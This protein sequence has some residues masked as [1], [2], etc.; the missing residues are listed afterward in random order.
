MYLFSEKKKKKK[1]KKWWLSQSIY[2]I[3]Y[4]KTLSQLQ[5]QNVQFQFKFQFVLTFKFSNLYPLV[6]GYGMIAIHI[7]WV[8]MFVCVRI[9]SQKQTLFQNSLDYLHQNHWIWILKTHSHTSTFHF[10]ALI[11]FIC[12]SFSIFSLSLVLLLFYQLLNLLSIY[13][14]ANFNFSSI[15]FNCIFKCRFVISWRMVHCIFQNSIRLH[16]DRMFI[17]PFINVLHQMQVVQSYRGIFR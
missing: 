8:W 15:Q 4:S 3:N 16:F 1:K 12:L 11:S 2:F 9:W 10:D 5:R 6:V 17:G 7:H 13:N 14:F